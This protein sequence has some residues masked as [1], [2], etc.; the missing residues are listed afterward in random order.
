MN[1]WKKQMKYT[2]WGFSEWFS[3]LPSPAPLSEA[4]LGEVHS[5]L[6]GLG[7]DAYTLLHPIG[8]TLPCVFLVCSMALNYG[9]SPTPN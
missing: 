4:Q 3:S 9:H 7:L 6:W 2:T 8:S 5:T 1:K